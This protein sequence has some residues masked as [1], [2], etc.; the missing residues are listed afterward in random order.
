LS[1]KRRDIVRV[2]S[3]IVA[4]SLPAVIGQWSLLH[5]VRRS[6]LEPEDK[7]QH[8][9]KCDCGCG[10]HALWSVVKTKDGVKHWFLNR[11]HLSHWEATLVAQAR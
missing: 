5:H 3:A 8:T 11:Q 6:T 1:A 9:G 2:V 7:M 4:D 10:H